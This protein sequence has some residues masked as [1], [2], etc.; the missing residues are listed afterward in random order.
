MNKLT[1]IAFSLPF[2]YSCSDSLPELPELPELKMPDL[3]IITDKLPDM[4]SMP[5]LSLPTPY[6][7][8]IFQGSVLDRYS[9]NQLQIG[10]SKS[11]V[12]ELIGSPSI[13]DLFHNTQWDYINFSTLHQKE[14]IRYRLTLIFDGEILTEIDSTGLDKLPP[15]TIA[16]KALEDQ[17]LAVTNAEGI[18][19]AKRQD[20]LR[21]A[22]QVQVA[23]ELAEKQR[24]AEQKAKAE[25]DE[26]AVAETKRQDELRL[27]QQVQVAKEQAEADE[28][29][30]AEAKRQDELRLVQ[31]DKDVKKEPELLRYKIIRGDSLS[32][33]ARRYRTTVK[34]IKALNGLNSDFIRADD[35]LLVPRNHEEAEKVAK[36]QAEADR[37][38]KEKA[39]QIAKD[40]EAKRI[41][42]EKAAQIA[43]DDEAK[44]IAEEKAA[45]IAKDDEAKRIA[46][47][48]AAQIAK[49]DEAKRITE[50]ALIAAQKEEEVRIAEENNKPWY[51]FWK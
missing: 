9:V 30:V 4:P 50:E 5:D 41:A 27:A 37:V 26:K 42:K 23:K 43:K 47:E 18:A 33:I 36:E 13:I 28:K 39:A 15:L 3:S 10:M 44:R 17:R 22:Q 49:D 6:K 12:T 24:K 51:Q 38:A 21:L 19:E 45:Q 7:N 2:L 1:L 34:I 8:D 29:A 32:R 16:E 48:K 46:E 25:A 11:Q 20:E 35:Y 14:D 40:D 31:K